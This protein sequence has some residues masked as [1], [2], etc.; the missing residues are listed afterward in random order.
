MLLVLDW[1]AGKARYKGRNLLN[2][3]SKIINKCGHRNKFALALYDSK[4]WIKFS[5]TTFEQPCLRDYSFP[6]SDCFKSSWSQRVS[7]ISVFLC[8][9]VHLVTMHMKSQ[10]SQVWLAHSSREI[11][12]ITRGSD[13][14]RW[15]NFE[16][17]ESESYITDVILRMP[18]YCKRGWKIVGPPAW[19]FKFQ[20]KLFCIVFF[21]Q[22]LQLSYVEHSLMNNYCFYEDY[23]YTYNQNLKFVFK[24]V[25]Y[26]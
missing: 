12:Q 20:V 26:V 23:I 8:W 10:F 15:L 18:L 16:N 5:V 13:S 14:L 19:N 9:L 1:K 7:G 22:I 24:I 21:P 25:K 6:K 11:N 2:K 4:D 3:W 17:C